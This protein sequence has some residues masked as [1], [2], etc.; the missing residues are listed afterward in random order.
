MIF[1]SS[2][3][4]SSNPLT[5]SLVPAPST[6]G[7]LDYGHF[8]WIIPFWRRTL[9]RCAWALWL[10]VLRVNDRVPCVQWCVTSTQILLTYYDHFLN[11]ELHKGESS[12]WPQYTQAPHYPDYGYNMHTKY[13]HSH[14]SENMAD[15]TTR[16]KTPLVWHSRKFS[17]FDRIC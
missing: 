3:P 11:F 17:C 6:L 15:H 16:L 9:S 4:L 14:A 1:C 10:P 8:L 5:F 13:Q 12:D 2:Y 7:V